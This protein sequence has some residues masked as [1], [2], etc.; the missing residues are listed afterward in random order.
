[1]TLLACSADASTFALGFVD[2]TEAAQSHE[3]LD[4]LAAASLANVQAR[5]VQR[6]QASV[7]GAT[8]TLAAQRLSMSGRFPDGSGLVQHVVLFERGLRVYQATVVGKSPSGEA[9]ETFLAGI[10]VPQ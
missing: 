5:D 3:V 4:Q 9:V 1:M 2:C 10:R 8:S 6:S 7:R